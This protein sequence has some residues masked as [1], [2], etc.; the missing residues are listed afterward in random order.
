VGTKKPTKMEE[1]VSII[2]PCF[3]SEKFIS[4][5]ILSVQNQS[6]LNWEMIIIDD[7]STDNT[8]KIIQEF[9]R[10]DN[11]IKLFELEKNSGAG[12]ARNFGLNK[13]TGRFIAFLDA[14]DLWK[15]EKLKIQIN[16][17]KTNHQFF[18]FSFYDCIDENG[19]SLHKIIKAPQTLTYTQLFFCN[20]VGNLTGIYDANYFGKIPISTIR[21]RQDWMM[22]LIILKKIKTAQPIP[23][24]LAVYRFRKDS[25]SASK[26]DLLQHNFK[27]YNQFHRFNIVTSFFCMIVF[28]FV[29]LFIKPL[30]IKKQD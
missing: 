10:N 6:Y 29:Q 12:A 15:P 7:F 5:A 30:Y 1:L 18:T 20:F 2:T 14:D 23:E 3:N 28:L 27:V 11:R 21:K 8:V 19:N 4:E 16:F 9:T 26:I 25:I 17:L 22:W 24:S 13:A